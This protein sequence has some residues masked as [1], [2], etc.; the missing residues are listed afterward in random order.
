LLTKE[1]KVSLDSSPES[2]PGLGLDVLRAPANPAMAGCFT[3]TTISEMTNLVDLEIISLKNAGLL[4]G[5][6]HASSISHDR[7][8]DVETW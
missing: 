4:P 3:F 1:I 6:H 2:S 7:W 8:Q 5:W